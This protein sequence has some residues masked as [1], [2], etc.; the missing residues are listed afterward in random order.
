V[1]DVLV[2][3]KGLQGA[4]VVAVV[5]QLVAAGGANFGLLQCGNQPR[6]YRGPL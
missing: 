6:V 1:L 2:P 5:C 4:S 3:E